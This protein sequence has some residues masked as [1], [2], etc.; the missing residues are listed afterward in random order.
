MNKNIL[1]RTRFFSGLGP[2]LLEE[3]SNIAVLKKYRAGDVIFAEG[4]AG[5]GFHLVVEG[6]VKIYKNSG[7]GKERL[8]NVFGPGEPFGEAAVFLDR[9]YPSWA[10]AVSDSL[11]AFFPRPALRGLAAKN[12]ELTL[13]LTAVLS[14]RL[15]G[16]TGR[17]EADSLDVSARLAGY[18][19][20]MDESE[21]TGRVELNL[22]KGQLA[23]LLGTAPE[24]ISRVLGR[25]KNAAVISEEKPFIKILDRD[26]LDD[27]ANG[28]PL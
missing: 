13:E 14:R 28:E 11:T 18:I 17:L 23:S 7:G 10:Q 22:T 12:P 1:S 16:L 25:L 20:E 4:D 21:R 24:T 9:G 26:K 8:L 27:I 2:E 19:L 15:A 3:L 6:R 5:A